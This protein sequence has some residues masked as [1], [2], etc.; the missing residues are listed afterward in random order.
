MLRL[1]VAKCR[2]VVSMAVSKHSEQFL[3]LQLNVEDKKCYI[4][5]L[6]LIDGIYVLVN[7]EFLEDALLRCFFKN[8]F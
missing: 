1:H 2:M 6:S 4:A 5:K 7:S 3:Q 8:W